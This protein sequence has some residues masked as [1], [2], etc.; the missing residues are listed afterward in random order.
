MDSIVRFRRDYRIV[1]W[2]PG[3]AVVSSKDILSPLSVFRCNISSLFLLSPRHSVL[4]PWLVPSNLSPQALMLR[5]FGPSLLPFPCLLSLVH[6]TCSFGDKPPSVPFPPP[7]T[8]E[9][10]AGRHPGFDHSADGRRS[11]GAY[12]SSRA[13]TPP[14]FP[15]CESSDSNG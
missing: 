15:P 9:F 3:R 4:S 1:A 8:L 14:S 2:S 7:S 11:R 10:P 5:P 12:G 13:S 6:F